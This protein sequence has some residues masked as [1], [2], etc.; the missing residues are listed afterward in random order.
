MHKKNN[1]ALGF[2]FVTLLVDITGW[3]IIIPVLPKLI[4]TLGHCDISQATVYGVWLA[5]IYSVMQFFVSP[6]LGGLSDWY[7][8]RPVLLISLMGFGIDYLI[9]AYAPNMIWLFIIRIL[10]GAAGASFTTA[11]AY[12]ADISTPEKRAQNFGIIGIAFGLGFMIG[13]AIGGILG[14]YGLRIPFYFCAGLSLLNTLYGYFVL[15]ESLLPEHRRKFEWKRANPIGTLVQLSKYPV[16]YGMI[17]SL[18]CIYLAAQ[19][20]QSIWAYYT[21]Y[22]FGWDESMIGWSLAAVGVMVFIVQGGLIRIVLP[23]LG[24]KRSIYTGFLLYVV[25][26]SLFAF[27]PNT[28][29][30]FLFII[31]YCLA[32]ITGPALQGIMSGQVPP[33]AQGELQGGLTSLISVTSIIGPLM[34]G[35]LFRYFTAQGHINFPGAPFL[36]GAI[37]TLI[38]LVLAMRSLSKTMKS[39]S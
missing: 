19:A 15:P 27:A 39:G 32:G 12:I 25:G 33:N 1:A 21:K 28:L 24:N 3:G 36:T 31:P 2:I 7:G 14:H 17:G 20:T 11:S 18:V 23:K 13:P 4:M 8:R 22:K 5:T 35:Y 34:M 30:M 10:T 26:F 37:L 16:V 38:G 29:M 6:I 9:L